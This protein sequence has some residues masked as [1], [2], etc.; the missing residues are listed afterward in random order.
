ATAGLGEIVFIGLDLDHPALEKWKGRPRLVAA[1]VDRDRSQ[2][3]RIE[4]EARGSVTH[5]GYEDLVGQLGAALDQFPG[6]TLVNFTTVSVITLAYL[7]LVAPGDFF[8]L[9]QLGWPRHRTWITFPLAAL[10][11]IAFACFFGREMHG[12]GG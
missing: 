10:G 5:L 3:E 8:L 12:S 1:L 11:V 2:R 4:H 9:S 6:V 7:L